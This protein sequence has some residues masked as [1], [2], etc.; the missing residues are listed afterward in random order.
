[1]SNISNNFVWVSWLI[2]VLYVSYR[3]HNHHYYIILACLLGTQHDLVLDDVLMHA[4][5]SVSECITILPK[6]EF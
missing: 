4:F 6:Q 3:Q 1:M 5:F 2:S